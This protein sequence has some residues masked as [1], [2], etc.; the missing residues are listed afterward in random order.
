MP[1]PSAFRRGFTVD[2]GETIGKKYKVDSI[3]VGHVVK[4]QNERYEFP[5]T[6]VFTSAL[7]NPK[8]F[9]KASSDALLKA[10]KSHV[11]KNKIVY[12]A[13]GSPYDCGFGSPRVRCFDENTVTVKSTGK[14]TRLRDT[15]T[16]KQQ[17]DLKESQEEEQK[18][19]DNEN[20]LE[21]YQII[22]SHWA[23][24][25][26][27]L[28]QQMIEPGTRI[29]K[30]KKDITQRGGWAHVTCLTKKSKKQQ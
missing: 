5:M 29:A 19:K 15:P 12:S 17:H 8:P 6:I 25:K 4:V 18:E 14:A 11:R 30:G 1:S 28:C 16:L 7:S 23:T 24:S 21:N 13:Y 3:K 9:T 26:C 22:S 27:A 2:E 10:L 20:L